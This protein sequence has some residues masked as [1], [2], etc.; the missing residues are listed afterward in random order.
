MKLDARRTTRMR[1]T[2]KWLLQGDNQGCLSGGN[3][4]IGKQQEAKERKKQGEKERNRDKLGTGTRTER[5][6]KRGKNKKKIEW[7]MWQ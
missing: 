2:L 5:T 1:K 6:W 4:W 3:K 7:R